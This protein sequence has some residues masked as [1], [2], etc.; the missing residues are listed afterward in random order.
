[1]YLSG[2]IRVLN[3]FLKMRHEDEVASLEPVV[4]K[5]V[6]VNVS[7]NG[8]SSQPV[9][10]ILVVNVFAQLFHHLDASMSAKFKLSLRKCK[11][12]IISWDLGNINNRINLSINQS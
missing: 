3:G 12:H 1:M 6:V 9:S 8:S 11:C 2:R 5:C 4:M 7:Q 10:D